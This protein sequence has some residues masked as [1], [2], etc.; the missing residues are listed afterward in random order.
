MPINRREARVPVLKPLKFVMPVLLFVAACSQPAPAPANKNADWDGFREKFINTA[1]QDRPDFAVYQGKHQFDG[2]LPD[3]SED[4]LAKRVAWLE[5]RAPNSHRLRSIDARQRSRFRTRLSARD[6]R[7]RDLLDG[8]SRRAS[9]ESRFLCRVLFSRPRVSPDVYLT[10]P[11][12]PLPDRLKAYIAW[13]K[14]LQP[15]SADSIEPQTAARAPDDRHRPHPVRRPRQLSHRRCAEGVRGGERC[16]AD[17]GVQECEH[18]G[19]PRALDFGRVARVAAQDANRSVCARRQNVLRN[20]P[21]HGAR[22]RPAGSPRGSR[23]G[24]HGQKRR[25]A[26]RGLRRVRAWSADSGVHR[27]GERSQAGRR[28]GGGC[29]Q[30]ARFTRSLHPR[31]RSRINSRH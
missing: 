25:G 30:T 16:R 28:G 11:Y 15:R 23:Q 4:G 13:A 14:A 20:A 7:S 19:G 2:K 27:E 5:V 22:G 8:N 24:R 26:Q 9:Q 18:D 3:W 31:E 21:Q 1:F 17:V 12:A 6:L 10:R 29:H